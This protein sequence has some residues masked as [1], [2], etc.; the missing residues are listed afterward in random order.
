MK[1]GSIVDVLF[2]NMIKRANTG[3]W[4]VED[5]PDTSEIGVTLAMYTAPW[6]K[7]CAPACNLFHVYARR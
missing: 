2:L 5:M 6:C 3:S 4:S 7:I 1:R